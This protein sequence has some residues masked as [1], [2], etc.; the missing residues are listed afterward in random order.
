MSVRLKICGITRLEDALL[1]AALGVDAIGFNFVAG[2]PRRVAPEVARDIGE[3]LPPFLTRVGVFADERPE[4]MEVTARAAGVHCLQLHG[5]ETPQ[6]CAALA[7][8]WYKA[9]RVTDA[10]RLEDVAR[11][12]CGTF[13]LDGH[14]PGVRGGSGTTFDWSVARRAA[15]HGRVI[16]AGGLTPDNVAGA[17]AAARPY[18]VDVSSGVEAGPGVKDEA[19]MRAFVRRVGEAAGR[20]VTR[21]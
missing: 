15:A 18:A 7:L 6:V 10:F 13:L 17:I 14:A 1:A 21:P 4:A 12:G 3:A 5:E 2:S 8:P 19:R 16:L 11:Y 20:S 9:F